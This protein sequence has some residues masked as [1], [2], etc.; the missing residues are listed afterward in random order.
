MLG[1][2]SR[3]LVNSNEKGKETKTTKEGCTESD[4]NNCLNFFHPS[5]GCPCGSIYMGGHGSY[6]NALNAANYL[7]RQ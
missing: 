2:G 1:F 7:P 5:M 3:R 6:Y 4:A